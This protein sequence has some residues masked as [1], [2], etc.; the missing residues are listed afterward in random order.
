MSRT[1]EYF[2][3]ESFDT[4]SSYGANGAII[5][6]KPHPDTCATIGTESFYLCDSGSQ[7][8]DGTTDITRTVHF[9]NPTDYQKRCYTRVLQGCINL[10]STIF[11]AG[12][13]GYYLD[14]VAR[15]PLWLDGLDYKH[16]TGHGVGS[17]LNVHE[18]PTSISYRQSRST[19]QE[20]M[21]VTIGLLFILL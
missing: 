11:P 12:T 9:G 3:S 17:Y 5:H 18:G 13:T 1:K 10:T 7:F 2:V 4:I 15:G 14:S 16:G 8:K 21:T 6:Y 20:G 19:L